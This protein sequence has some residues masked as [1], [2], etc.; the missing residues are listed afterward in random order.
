MRHTIFLKRIAILGG[1]YGKIFETK[2][3][4]PNWEEISLIVHFLGMVN[5]ELTNLKVVTIT[6]R[7][8]NSINL[9][10]LLKGFTFW[11]IIDEWNNYAPAP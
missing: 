11:L 4:A 5:D 7:E 2:T 1:K 10:Q 9:A 3:G 8:E 6:T